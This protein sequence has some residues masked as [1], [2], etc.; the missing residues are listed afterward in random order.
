LG[1]EGQ[2]LHPINN[3]KKPIVYIPEFRGKIQVI[4]INLGIKIYR[5]Y[6]KPCIWG[7]WVAQW[8]RHLPLAQVMI[9]ESWD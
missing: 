5:F 9:P 8:V 7:A 1:K 6:L 2:D 4:G 3:I